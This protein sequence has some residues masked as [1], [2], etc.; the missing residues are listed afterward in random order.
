MSTDI[1]E[2]VITEVQGSGYGFAI[3]LDESTDV[4]N[5]A[6]LL[7]YVRYVTKYAIRSELLLINEIR[8]TTKGEDAFELVDNFF[9][10]NDL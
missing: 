1:K 9:K 5:C 6:Q 2:E 7:V 3:Q 8:T 4:S 10:E